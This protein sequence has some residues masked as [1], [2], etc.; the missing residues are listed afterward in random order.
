M[1]A[2]AGTGTPGANQDGPLAG[3]AFSPGEVVTA[4]GPLS[5]NAPAPKVDI[6][7]GTNLVTKAYDLLAYPALRPEMIFDQFATVRATRQSHNGSSVQ[8]TFVGDLPEATTPLLENID[9]D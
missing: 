2:A 7:L 5:I 9:V 4:A 1:A 8:F 3:P 6:A